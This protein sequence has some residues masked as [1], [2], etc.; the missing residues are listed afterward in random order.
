M[1][2]ETV[3]IRYI[4]WC[5]NPSVDGSVL[6]LEYDERAPASACKAPP[7]DQPDLNSDAVG[8]F[9]RA[10]LDRHHEEVFDTRAWRCV[11][12]D[13]PAKELHHF[14]INY[15]SSTADRVSPRFV[16]TVIDTPAPI[17]ISGGA[18]DRDARRMVHEFYE[19]A[20]GPKPDKLPQ[21]PRNC[22]RCGKV[23][24]V[25]LCG[26]CRTLAYCS[27]ECQTLGWPSHKKQCKM[28]QENLAGR[29]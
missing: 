10:L 8:M 23:S 9:I 28:S 27:K 14:A 17:C 20:L 19:D 4:V 11:S 1:P 25:K 3:P 2:E 7:K 16:P 24:E 13:K 18:C 26:G 22:D 5:G 12:C 21:L 15:L 29:V 6:T